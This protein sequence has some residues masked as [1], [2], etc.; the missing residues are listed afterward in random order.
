MPMYIEL[1]DYTNIPQNNNIIKT[2]SK[3]AER[4]EKN[5]NYKKTNS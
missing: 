4:N 2:T 5:P 3:S 1:K